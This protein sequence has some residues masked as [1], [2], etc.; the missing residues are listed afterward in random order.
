MF[1][2]EDSISM[3]IPNI[4]LSKLKLTWNLI[5]RASKWEISILS[6]TFAVNGLQFWGQ[7]LELYSKLRDNVMDVEDIEYRKNPLITDSPKTTYTK[8]IRTHVTTHLTPPQLKKEYITIFNPNVHQIISIFP[9]T[10]YLLTEN[11][12]GKSKVRLE[13]EAAMFGHNLTINPTIY[14]I[15]RYDGN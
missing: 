15:I 10:T 5:I 1:S 8:L 9:Y 2:P 6:K 4:L 14:K 7:L 13:E 11:Y 12:L 3:E